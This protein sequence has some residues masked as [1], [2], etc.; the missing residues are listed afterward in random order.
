MVYFLAGVV[1][2]ESWDHFEI[3]RRKFKPDIWK[4]GWNRIKKRKKRFH[5]HIDFNKSHKKFMWLNYWQFFDIRIIPS[6]LRESC[7]T[8][9]NGIYMW[10]S[11]LSLVEDER[12]G[13]EISCS[14][15][16]LSDRIVS[17][18]KVQTFLL[19]FLLLTNNTN[20]R[21]DFRMPWRMIFDAHWKLFPFL[22]C[23]LRRKEKFFSEI[24]YCCER[25]KTCSNFSQRKMRIR[26]KNFP[27]SKNT[28]RLK[29]ASDDFW[30]FPLRCAK[31]AILMR[32]S[33]DLWKLIW[34]WR[35]IG[36]RWVWDQLWKLYRHPDIL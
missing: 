12:E 15:L 7:R 21:A 9:S 18:G 8:R 32:G 30:Y 23:N 24:W 4:K 11:I 20:Y 34:K 35:L 29:N 22:R 16:T 6:L 10:E 26:G 2:E 3:F 27:W 28:K 14:A 25:K 17:N 33:K 13:G 5:I 1:G 31:R 19:L 36:M